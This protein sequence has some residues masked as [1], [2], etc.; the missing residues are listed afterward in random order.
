MVIRCWF[1]FDGFIVVI[2]W[3]FIII[4]GNDC[5]IDWVKKE[6]ISC[7]SFCFVILM[8]IFFDFINCRLSIFEFCV[9]S[10]FELI[11]FN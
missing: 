5:G 6:K 7:L 11:E 2:Y 9:R 10:S 3:S 4:F 1:W 8:V